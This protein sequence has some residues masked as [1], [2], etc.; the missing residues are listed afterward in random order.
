MFMGIS[1]PDLGTWFDL[2]TFI[3]LDFTIFLSFYRLA[4]PVLR[5]RAPL[6]HCLPFVPTSV[7]YWPTLSGLYL[8]QCQKTHFWAWKLK[9]LIFL[10][11]FPVFS[12]VGYQVCSVI[13]FVSL[14]KA[15]CKVLSLFKSFTLSFDSRICRTPGHLV[16]WTRIRSQV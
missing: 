1:Q 7:A 16:V 12:S 13:S 10:W 2:Q 5:H 6:V 3:G 8:R 4:H 9:I 14:F 15:I 11:F